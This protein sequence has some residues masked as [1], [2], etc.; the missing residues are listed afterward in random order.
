MYLCVHTCVQLPLYT[1]E[2]SVTDIDGIGNFSEQFNKS[3]YS[4]I[5]NDETC[6]PFELQNINMMAM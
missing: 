3:V 2:I 6:T 1:L 4:E 5:S